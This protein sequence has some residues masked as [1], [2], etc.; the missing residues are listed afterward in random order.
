MNIWLQFGLGGAS[1]YILYTFVTKLFKYLE[2]KNKIDNKSKVN[3]MDRL[4]ERLD[5]VAESNFEMAKTMGENNVAQ[6]KDIKAIFKVLSSQEGKL[7]SINNSI[8]RI[9]DRTNM[10]VLKKE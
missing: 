7:D 6:S 9:D 10:C 8:T 5:K 1:L 3:Q 2:D 4:I